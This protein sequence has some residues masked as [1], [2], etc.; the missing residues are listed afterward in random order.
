MRA[1]SVFLTLL[2]GSGLAAAAV[3]APRQDLC[4]VLGYD[5]ESVFG[6]CVYWDDC[7]PSNANW[8]GCGTADEK[9]Q[10]SR[11]ERRPLDKECSAKPVSWTGID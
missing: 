5:Q 8:G 1:S 7:G 11:C 4:C 6:K 2:G 9:A 10:C 3:L